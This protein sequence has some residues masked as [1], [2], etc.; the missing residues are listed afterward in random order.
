MEKNLNQMTDHAI[1]VAKQLFDRDRVTGSSAN[2]SFLFGQRVYITGSGSCFGRLGPDDFA[3]LDLAGNILSERKPSKEWPLHLMIYKNKSGT[4]AVLHTHSTYSVLWSFHEFDS[5]N[6]IIPEHT[7]YLKMKLG[8][9]GLIPYEKPGSEA[10]FD[11]FNKRIAA[12]DGY[13]LK[14]HGPVVAGKDILDAFYSLEELEESAKIACYL[15]K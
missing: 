6:D 4:G 7:P 8:T 3:V 15:N 5:E 10:L 12:S 11:T 9:V 14:Q 1:W 2:L 13:I